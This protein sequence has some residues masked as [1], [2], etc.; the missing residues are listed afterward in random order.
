MHLGASLHLILMVALKNEKRVAMVVPKWMSKQ[1][2][3]R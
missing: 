1:G 2:H 3:S